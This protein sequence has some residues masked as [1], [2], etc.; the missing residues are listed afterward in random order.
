MGFVLL[1]IEVS[2]KT[3]PSLQWELDEGQGVKELGRGEE[4]SK[5]SH[6]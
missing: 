2:S 4:R 3:P 5:K 6:I 1:C